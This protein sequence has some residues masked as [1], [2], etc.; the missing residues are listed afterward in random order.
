MNELFMLIMT[1]CSQQT[2]ALYYQEGE[3]DII[4]M[5]YVEQGADRLEVDGAVVWIHHAD[6]L[7]RFV[8]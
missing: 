7:K 5:E 3:L 8:K 2:C 6:S 1:L 4:T